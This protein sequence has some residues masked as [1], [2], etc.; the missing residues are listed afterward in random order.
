MQDFSLYLKM[1]RIYLNLLSE[2]I[3]KAT[4]SAKNLLKSGVNVWSATCTKQV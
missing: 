3:I 4:F 2:D 1:Y